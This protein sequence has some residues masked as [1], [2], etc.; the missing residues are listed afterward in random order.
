MKSCRSM[1]DRYIDRLIDMYTSRQQVERSASR[2]A[3]SWTE[4]GPWLNFGFGT[5]KGSVVICSPPSCPS[6]NQGWL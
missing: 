2:P 6:H 1:V 3:Q 5:F 4:L